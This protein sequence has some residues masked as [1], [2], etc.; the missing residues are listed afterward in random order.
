MI[1][2]K[3]KRRKRYTDTQGHLLHVKVHAANIHD[4]KGGGD[5]FDRDKEKFPLIKKFLADE[6]YRGKNHVEKAMGLKMEISKK[7]IK[8]GWTVLAKRWAVER[9]FAWGNIVN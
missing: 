8:N 9:T 7:K 6:D 4:T 3:G 5:I 2:K 1:G